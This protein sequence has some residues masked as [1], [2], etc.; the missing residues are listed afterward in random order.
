MRAVSGCQVLKS[1]FRNTMIERSKTVEVFVS[2]YTL[3]SSCG[4]QNVSPS[5]TSLLSNLK[6]IE[7]MSWQFFLCST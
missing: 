1:E 2:W 4:D 5:D 3:T 6:P 7:V